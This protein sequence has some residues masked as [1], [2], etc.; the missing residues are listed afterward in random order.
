[1]PCYVKDH[2]K[3]GRMFICGKLGPH[4]ADCG[5]VGDYLCDYPVGKGKT[6]D[7]SMCDDHSTEVAPNLHY[8]A[9]HLGMW[10]AYRDSGALVHEL[11]NVLPFKQMGLF[12]RKDTP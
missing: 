10:Q 9:P 11:E 5:D 3:L 12:D 2:P 6:C 8:C 4:C 1:M 7:R